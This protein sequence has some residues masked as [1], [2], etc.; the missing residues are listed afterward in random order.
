M[1]DLKKLSSLT[2]DNLSSLVAERLSRLMAEGGVPLRH[3]ANLLT[4]LCRLSPSQARRKL[5]GANWSFGEVLA[6]VR[7]FGVSLDKVFSSLPQDGVAHAEGG[8]AQSLPMQDAVFMMDKWQMPCRVR[9]GA[10]VV[11]A[12]GN[13]ELLTA[14]SPQGWVV[15]TFGQLDRLGVEGHR[16]RADQVLLT[17]PPG[18]SAIRIA[19]LDDDFGVSETLADWF[20]AAGYVAA[21]FSSGDQLLASGITN[22]DAF[23]VDFML[24]GGDSSAA[25]INTIRLTLPDAPIVLLTGKLRD[26]KVSESDLTTMLRTSNVTF[27]EKPVRPPV[28]AATIESTLDQAVRRKMS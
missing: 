24:A 7:R 15:S 16:Y 13:D 6:V 9:L 4:V 20:G 2:E 26:G 5:Q 21:A 1:D 3:Q 11:G 25:V 8:T 28:L 19:I 10:M 23:V 14:Q 18:K 12:V 17:P 22:Y 27:F